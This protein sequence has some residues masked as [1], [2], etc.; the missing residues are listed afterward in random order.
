MNKELET[1][2]LIVYKAVIGLDVQGE[3]LEALFD[4]SQIES[5]ADLYNALE[6]IETYQKQSEGQNAPTI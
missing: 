4:E 6:L 3:M 1:A 2:L 5:W